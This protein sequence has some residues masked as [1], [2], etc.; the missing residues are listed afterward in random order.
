[1]FDLV[2]L[3]DSYADTDTVHARLNQDLL[4]FI[5]C[6]SQWIQEDLG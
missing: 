3:L 4:V 2:R 1:M 5:A 6:N